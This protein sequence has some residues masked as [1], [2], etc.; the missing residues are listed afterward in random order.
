MQRTPTRAARL[1]SPPAKA[2]LR[3]ARYLSVLNP[4][5]GD[6]CS[7]CVAAARRAGLSQIRVQEWIV[8]VSF[9]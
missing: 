4:G 2:A 1:T 7:L 8:P 9:Y 3:S 6:R 5:L